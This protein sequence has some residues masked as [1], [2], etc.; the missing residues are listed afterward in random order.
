MKPDHNIYEGGV[1]NPVYQVHLNEKTME[2][3]KE[4]IINV[5]KAARPYVDDKAQSDHPADSLVLEAI[6]DLLKQLLANSPDR[7]QQ[8]TLEQMVSFARTMHDEKIPDDFEGDYDDWYKS[9]LPKPDREQGVIEKAIKWCEQKIEHYDE[10]YLKADKIEANK[11][12][13]FYLGKTTALHDC[14]LYIQSLQPKPDREQPK[15]H[16]D[17]GMV[18]YA[19]GYCKK[20]EYEK[21]DT[22]YAI[23]WLA[24]MAG[25][26]K[27]RKL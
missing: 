15:P 2:Q 26:S 13:N 17:E 14:K 18:E 24:Y 3:N 1:S 7:E 23:A 19:N 11:R 16:V 6:Y 27:A 10:E 12:K 4:K 9:K 5:L 20:M 22:K 25:F 21:G 8:F